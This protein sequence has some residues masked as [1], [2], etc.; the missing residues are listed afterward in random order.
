AAAARAPPAPARAAVGAAPFRAAPRALARH[1]GLGM[2]RRGPSATG[3]SLARVGAPPEV[4]H[5]A[6]FPEHAP[7]SMW[8][9]DSPPACGSRAGAPDEQLRSELREAVD[10]HRLALRE[11]AA[12]QKAE[13][14]LGAEAAL[15]FFR[16]EIARFAQARVS[17]QAESFEGHASRDCAAAAAPEGYV[18]S[19]PKARARQRGF[20][21]VAEGEERRGR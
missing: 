18:C 3:L 6:P 21:C 7:L 9:A 17:G 5:T 15:E 19:D 14:R 13:L 11:A 8:G 4:E 10:E 20:G 12:Q 16:G 2:V 1:P